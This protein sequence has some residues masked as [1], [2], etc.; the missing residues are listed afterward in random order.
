MSADFE[1]E[2]C[3]IDVFPGAY[4]GQAA[5]EASVEGAPLC[6][7][8]NAAAPEADIARAFE[9][10]PSAVVLVSSADVPAAEEAV[11]QKASDIPLCILRFPPIVAT[12]MTGR[13]RDMVNAIY[14]GIYLKVKDSDARASIIHGLDAARA[15]VLAAGHDGMFYVDDGRGPGVNDIAEALAYRISNKRIASL[16]LKRARITALLLDIV[17]LGGAHA[18]ERLRRDT[19]DAIFSSAD[20]TALTGFD[21]FDTIAYLRT[22]TYTEDDL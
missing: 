2:V 7:I 4:L 8:V 19:T 16:P 17:T 10:R 12:G 20:F 21:P 11:R 22:H 15:A 13:W 14:R 9:R 5:R 6:L 18:R 1:F 3:G